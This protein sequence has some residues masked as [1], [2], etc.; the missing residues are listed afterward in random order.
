MKIGDVV[1]PINEV[2]L[3]NYS[4]LNRESTQNRMTFA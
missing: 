3:V 1:N 2:R 4:Y